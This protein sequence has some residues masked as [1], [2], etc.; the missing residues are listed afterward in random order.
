MS[1]ITLLIFLTTTTTTTAYHFTA[2]PSPLRHPP[3]T[4]CAFTDDGV[5]LE[6]L[7]REQSDFVSER[8]WAQ[9]HTPRSLSLALVGEVGEL[10]ELF[11]WR[12]DEGAPPGLPEWTDSEKT[13]LADELADVLSYVI[14]LA[15]VSDVDLTAA[16]LR[17]LQKNRDKYPA[18]LVRGS[19]AKYTQYRTAARGAA[20]AAAAAAAE[21]AEAAAEAREAA[22]GSGEWGTPDWVNAAYQRAAARVK[23]AEEGQQQEQAPPPPPPPP[24][25]ADAVAPSATSDEKEGMSFN[26]RAAARVEELLK[27]QQP[28]EPEAA[29]EEQEESESESANGGVEFE[30]LDELFGFM[31]F[32]DGTGGL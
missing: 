9:F 15:D 25:R 28:A 17:K 24:P 18:D 4:A 32:G 3:I 13:A 2:P 30:S 31:E 8:D 5:T 22:G 20:A 27:Q 12:G 7:R 10:C 26:Q 1:L 14:R 11:Q 19:A 16:F 23:A 6:G 29:A 21:A